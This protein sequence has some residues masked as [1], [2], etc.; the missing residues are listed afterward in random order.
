MKQNIIKLF[1]FLLCCCLLPILQTV[2]EQDAYV[3]TVCKFDFQ[4]DTI[5]KAPEGL[6]NY[7]VSATASILPLKMIRP[8]EPPKETKLCAFAEKRM[9]RTRRFV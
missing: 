4:G 2:A 1:S 5:G 6:L 8:R 3:K 7:S 9:P